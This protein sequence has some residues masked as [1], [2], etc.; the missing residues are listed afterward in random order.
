MLRISVGSSG[1]CD[2]WILRSRLLLV[3]RLVVV[4]GVTAGQPEAGEDKVD[5][6]TDEGESKYKEDGDTGSDGGAKDEE[7]YQQTESSPS[8]LPGGRGRQGISLQLCGKPG[9]VLQQ[10]FRQLL[11]LPPLVFCQ[12]HWVLS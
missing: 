3:V 1:T 12:C 4:T 5:G 8:D 11:E 2:V 10:L 7:P 6:R 9:I